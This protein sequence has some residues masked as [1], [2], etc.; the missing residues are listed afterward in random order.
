MERGGYDGALEAGMTV[1]VES[2]VGEVGGGEGVKLEEQALITEI[3][4]ESTW[5]NK[6]FL[7]AAP[8]A[9]EGRAARLGGVQSVPCRAKSRHWRR[10]API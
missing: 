3:G 7:R 5:A 4:A 6:G 2:Y 10:Q 8:S 9:C 1:C